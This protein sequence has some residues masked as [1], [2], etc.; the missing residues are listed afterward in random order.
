MLKPQDIVILLK[1]LSKASEPWSQGSMAVELGMSASEVNAAI[2]RLLKSHLARKIDKR[3]K[4]INAAVLEFLV[5]GLKYVFPIER[6][7]PTRGILAGHAANVFQGKI[8]RNEELPPVWPDP[9]G[10]EKG[11]AIKPLYKSVPFAVS[12][13]KKLYNYLAI[14]DALRSNS[15][16][17]RQVAA[18][19]LKQELKQT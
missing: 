14:A 8:S 7:E 4:P 17:D 9:N 1:I 13:D 2:R 6:G 10:Q 11:Y 18:K 15:A 3:V 16:R 5:H 12:K 19:L